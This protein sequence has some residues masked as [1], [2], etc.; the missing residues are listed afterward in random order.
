MIITN[1]FTLHRDLSI[2][3][4]PTNEGETEILLY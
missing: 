3:V 4:I 2:H 1:F